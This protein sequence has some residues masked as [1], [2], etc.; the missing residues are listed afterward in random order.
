MDGQHEDLGLR[1]QIR[2]EL[3]CF[4]AVH[5]RHSHIQQGDIR[6]LILRLEHCLV[7]VGGFADHFNILFA[8]QE[9]S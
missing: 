1:G 4:D 2:D 5:P 6:F 7:A 9:F 8:L 3:G